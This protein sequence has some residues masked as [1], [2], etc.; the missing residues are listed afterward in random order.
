QSPG[1]LSALAEK[2][3][4]D[5]YSKSDYAGV[6]RFLFARY[7]EDSDLWWTSAI[8]FDQ[9]QRLEKFLAPDPGS[10]I[11]HWRAMRCSWCAG[12]ERH[13]LHAAN[14]GA[15]GRTSGTRQRHGQR[16]S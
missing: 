13:A 9:G 12:S 8:R 4:R 5:I 15:L 2:K 14:S 11:A 7:G 10:N 16:H 1:L 6:I 3:Y